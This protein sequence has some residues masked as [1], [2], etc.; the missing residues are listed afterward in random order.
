MTLAEYLAETGESQRAFA[1]RANVEPRTLRDIDDGKDALGSTWA[2][3]ERATG[4]FVKRR[5]YFPHEY[6]YVGTLRQTA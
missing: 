3:I 4:G 5:A 2:K 6:E 1:K